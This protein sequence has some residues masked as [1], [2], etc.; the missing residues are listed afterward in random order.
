[1]G[2]VALVEKE[3]SAEDKGFGSYSL[4]YG[5]AADLQEG[6]ALLFL[7]GVCFFGRVNPETDVAIRLV[8]CLLYTSDA[9]DE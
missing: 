8:S 6:G 1:M 5:A 2:Q 3:T 4:G 7:V 9:A